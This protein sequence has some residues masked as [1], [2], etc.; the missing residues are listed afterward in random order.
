[1]DVVL[2]R[3]HVQKMGGEESSSPLGTADKVWALPI[4][5]ERESSFKLA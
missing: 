5:E 2:L 4:F 3:D 1:M